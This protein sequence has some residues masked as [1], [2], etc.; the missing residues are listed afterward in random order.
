MVPFGGL[1]DCVAHGFCGLH[2][3]R[4]S[5]RGKG[6]GPRW[7][8]GDSW[9]RPPTTPT[10]A[11]SRL[12][13]RALRLR[14]AS[15]GHQVQGDRSLRHDGHL[16]ASNLRH[17]LER[18]RLGDPHRAPRRNEGILVGGAS[19]DACAPPCGHSVTAGGRAAPWFSVAGRFAS[20]R[21]GRLSCSSRQ[22]GAPG[23]QR[24]IRLPG[25][26]QRRCYGVV[27][28]RFRAGAARRPSGAGCVHNFISPRNSP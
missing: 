24:W 25:R 20:H 26:L 14:P 6:V 1:G 8:S 3:G 18:K 23:A 7:R 16:L 15:R 4:H 27:G 21:D 2:R 12:G 28:R 13:W 10:H 17:Q 11:G 9:G 5:S 19:G 22:T